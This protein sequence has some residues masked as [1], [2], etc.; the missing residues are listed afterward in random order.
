MDLNKIYIDANTTAK[1]AG[2]MQFVQWVLSVVNK[3]GVS[4]NTTVELNYLAGG[5]PGLH[6]EDKTKL[7]IIN[8]IIKAGI[9]IDNYI[10]ND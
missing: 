3:S 2:G 10:H 4:N 7:D 5:Y 8:K 1:D 6:M 9:S